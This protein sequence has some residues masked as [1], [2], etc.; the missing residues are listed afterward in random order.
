MSLQI[1]TPWHRDSYDRFWQ[2]RLPQLLAKRLPL[3]SYQAQAENE[4]S[5]LVVVMLSSP[6]GDMQLDYRGI[7]QPD[8]DGLFTIDG[9]LRV[10]VPTA[11]NETLDSTEIACVGDQLYEYFQE[12]LGQAPDS[13]AWDETLAR[14]WFP[15]DRWVNEFFHE[16][17]QLLDTTN[18]VSRHTHL[19]R[20]YLLK[21]DQVIHPG[22]TG[23]VCPFETPEGPNI[24]RVFTIALG[25]AI[26][27]GRLVVIDP[28]QEAS[29]GISASMLPFLENNDPNRLLMAANMM[30]Q[31]IQPHNADPAWVQT[32]NEP[33]EEGFWYGYNLL[34][35][36]VSWG[37]ST[38]EDGII[39]SES[40]AR[41]LNDPF[42]VEAGDLLSNRHG[43]KGVVSDILP[44]DQMPH[45]PDGSPVELVYN[46]IGLRTRMHIGQARE[47]LLGRI[48]RHNGQPAIVPPFHAPSTE[49][50]NRRLTQAGLPDSGMEFLTDS[51][52]GPQLERPSTVGWVYW[53]RRAQLAKDKLRVSTA[54]GEGQVV[55][56]MEC[57]ILNEAGALHNLQEVVSTRSNRRK[58]AGDVP[59]LIA[60]GTI[61]SFGPPTPLFEG[62]VERLKIAG[63]RVE[64]TAGRLTFRFAYPEG[65]T[66]VLARPMAHPWLHERLIEA[67]GR[68]DGLRLPVIA[69]GEAY[70]VWQTNSGQRDS[71]EAE[72]E[73]LVEANARVK[74]M[75]ENKAPARLMKETVMQLET[76]LR[77]FFDA[78]LPPES[79]QIA[80]GQL[81]SGRAVTAPG[82]GLH[83]N[84][85][86]LPE[87][88][89]WALFGPFV[90]RE[91]KGNSPAAPGNPQ[92]VEALK[93][94]MAQ[95]WVIIHR[96]PGSTS[97]GLMAF[98]P[99]PQAGRVIRL[100]PLVCRWLNTDFDGDQVAVYL[101]VTPEAQAEAGE[102]LSAAGHL[103]RS[104]SLVKSLL[105]A[106]EAIWGLG[107]LS[108]SSAGR[109]KIA[110]IAGVQFLPW[111]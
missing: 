55:G 60:Q 23:R 19:R 101:P 57:A 84:Q 27:N 90:E 47:A 48:A 88:I 14:A 66:L 3:V 77:A 11:A 42:P 85:V 32:G 39:L 74:R 61:G 98:H 13:L 10:V 56:E 69:A 22:Q 76:Q 41:R 73:S 99:V 68:P 45:L 50:L 87:E 34:T 91:L 15:L 92:A 54:S 21:R 97:T 17:A 103:K 35:A 82:I 67:V 2:E 30:R 106:A 59:G 93:Q 46:F 100:N 40:A 5:L 105:P 108:L 81:F 29:L 4:Q 95:S 83:I 109:S 79:L 49:E 75:L 28:R 80:E 71:L 25:A 94:I 62:V 7:P 58:E 6:S 89:S 52:N 20:L 38:S 44:D 36:F 9:Q 1:L 104:P 64:L 65:E 111:Q 96:A 12:R 70:P 102:L 107:Y 86:G 72:F 43:T 63:V 53:S 31:T 8:M 37:E 18:W 24:G 26:R 51:K 16:K 110:W 78:L 33:D